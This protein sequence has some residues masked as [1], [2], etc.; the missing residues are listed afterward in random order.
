MSFPFLSGSLPQLPSRRTQRRGCYSHLLDF[1][2]VPGT[3][4]ILMSALVDRY[5]TETEIKALSDEGPCPM[6]E[7]QNSDQL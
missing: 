5:F 6:W 2:Y 7:N 3:Q 4:W 1:L